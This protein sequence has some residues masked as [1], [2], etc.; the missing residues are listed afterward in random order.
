MLL[1]LS[2]VS[3]EGRNIL[4][5]LRQVQSDV[6]LVELRFFIVLLVAGYIELEITVLELGYHR[7]AIVSD[8]A[9][10]LLN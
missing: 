8:A 1:A 3:Y 2:Q 10:L 5:K 7:P 9:H 4:L 6:I